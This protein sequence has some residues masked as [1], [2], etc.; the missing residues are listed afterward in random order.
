[1]TNSMTLCIRISSNRIRMYI[2]ASSLHVCICICGLRSY[3]LRIGSVFHT[4][5]GV[6]YTGRNASYATE[7]D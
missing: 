4:G 3:N 2:F 6:A 1:M 5:K 7:R